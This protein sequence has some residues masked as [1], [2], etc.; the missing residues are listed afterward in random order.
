M[1]TSSTK[2]QRRAARERL[3]VRREARARRAG[4]RGRLLLGG[5]VAVVLAFA[6]GIGVHAAA[7]SGPGG[8]SPDGPA[9]GPFV[10]PAHTT[11]RDGIV[12]PYGR[13]DARH[14]LTV[15]VDARC[16]FCAGFEQG[17]GATVKEQADAGEYR[18]EYRFATF[19][20]ASPGGGQGSRRAL[21]A[22][23][24]AVNEGPEKFVEYLRVLF[25][26]H[27]AQETED[28]FGS[29]ATLLELA[30]GVP[31]LRTPAFNRAVKE[32]T[33]MPWVEKVGQA[34]YDENVNG[35]P[36]VF[37]DGRRITVNSGRGIESITSDAFRAL[38]TENRRP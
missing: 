24:A 17:L 16:P 37:V 33:Y 21:N 26:N 15:W 12:L 30:D 31:G 11:G 8:S 9:G 5:A 29:T 19:L 38:V 10:Q 2:D 32:L 6:A 28:R 23:G 22:L 18:V 3:R 34:F 27:P 14:T 13:A 20:D 7:S 1:A 25:A 4:S 36:S 35:T